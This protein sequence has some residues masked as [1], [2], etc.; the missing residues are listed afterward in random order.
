MVKK[1]LF[2]AIILGFLLSVIMVSIASAQNISEKTIN[3]EIEKEIINEVVIKEL[4]SPATFEFTIKNLG[5]S[6]SFEIYSLVGV[7][8]FPEETFLINEGQTKKMRVEARPDESIKKNEGYFNFAYKIKG[9][10]TGIQED[11]LLIRVVNLNKVLGL[12]A[13]NINPDSEKTAI[14]IEN[15]ENIDFSEIEAEFS[16]AFFAHKENFNLKQRETKSFEAEIDK[17]KLIGLTAGPYILNANLK[18][19]GTEADLE[20]TIQFLEQPD[21]STTET[22]EGF[23]IFRHEIEKKNEGNV[24]IVAQINIEKGIF[25]RIFTNFNIPYYRKE[26]RGTKTEYIWQ[27]ELRP[28]ESL[29]VTAKTNWFVPI[30]LII[31]IVVIVILWRKYATTDL[32][33]KKRINHVRTKGGEFAL[34]VSI[35]AKARRYV[36]RVNIIDKL[37]PV[38]KLYERYGTIAPDRINEKNR[39]IEWNLESLNEN[40]EAVFSYIIYSKIGFVGRFE[41]PPA[42]AVYE[43]E[44]DVKEATSNRVFFMSEPKKARLE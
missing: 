41:L 35:L 44:G 39:R 42:A 4:S 34:K 12:R 6:D 36:E 15:K 10:T 14:Y 18:T 30:F 22:K 5:P 43:R 16:T 11:R 31:A 20:S 29:D 27:K 13:D 32:I 9:A 2:S 17:S 38:V 21:I 7:G 40:E 28:G 25:S 3:L 26:A 1:E 37:P 24:P 33:L 23:L 19:E 8:F